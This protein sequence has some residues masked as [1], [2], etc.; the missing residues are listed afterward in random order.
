[1]AVDTRKPETIRVR[2][3]QM[4]AGYVPVE[5]EDD[6]GKVTTVPGQMFTREVKEEYDIPAA[7]AERMIRAGIATRVPAKSAA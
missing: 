5:V 3:L 2:M 6:K 1:M 7:E 4:Q